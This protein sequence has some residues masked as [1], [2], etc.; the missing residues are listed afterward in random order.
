MLIKRGRWTSQ[1]NKGNQSNCKV[2]YVIPPMLVRSSHLHTFV[3]KCN[4][5][6]C[7]NSIG[8]GG[9]GRKGYVLGV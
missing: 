6:M 7:M 9:S 1:V 2:R 5:C 4:K 8:G 3:I